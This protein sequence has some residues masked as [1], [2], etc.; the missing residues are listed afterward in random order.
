MARSTVISGK[1]K[2]SFS[3]AAVFR[4][5]LSLLLPL[6]LPMVSNLKEL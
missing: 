2:S 5:L 4:L 1:A 6:T 3:S